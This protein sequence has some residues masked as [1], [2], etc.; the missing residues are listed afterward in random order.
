MKD[1][2]QY[3]KIVFLSSFTLTASFLFGPEAAR[4]ERVTSVNSDI[5]KVSTIG[6]IV[7]G[8]LVGFG[9][10]LGNGC[11]SG[12][13]VCGMARLSKRSFAAVGA[14]M[15]SA[16][17]TVFL[18][19][20]E[21]AWSNLT[22][23]LRSEKSRESDSQLGTLMITAPFLAMATI[24]PSLTTEQFTKDDKAK[25]IPA[26]VSGSLFASGLAVSGMCL[27]SKM[28]GFLNLRGITNG[29][30]D[31]TL[32]TVMAGATV[33]SMISYQFVK[34]YAFLDHGAQ[35][36]CPLVSEKFSIPS[37][38]GDIDWQLFLGAASFGIGWGISHVCP[39]PVLFNSALGDKA[40]LFLWSPSA[41]VG[42]RVAQA[43]KDRK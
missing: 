26:A 17:A 10:R 18:S 22:G 16:C 14:F 42:S 35:L 15:S 1:P 40:F 9:T 12:H 39:G 5:P 8:F 34:G 24:A 27:Q 2:K 13:G 29:S 30:W 36:D 32:A 4:D 33:M 21:A 41:Y 31:P 6:Q 37:K 25:I 28:Y 7:G 3:W 43:I 23:F 38:K 19:A 11:T 20:P